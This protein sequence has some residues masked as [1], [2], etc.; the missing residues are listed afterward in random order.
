MT[1]DM[2]DV[3]YTPL[4]CPQPPLID[5]DKL[6]A[7]VNRQPKNPRQWMM[8]KMNYQVQNEQ[9]PWDYITLYHNPRRGSGGP[10]ASADGWLAGINRVFPELIEYL[11]TPF[12]I[13]V[14]EFGNIVLLP[15]R[16]GHSG[17][18]WHRDDD[19]NGMRMYLDHEDSENNHLY[20]R[21]SVERDRWPLPWFY[22][23]TSPKTGFQEEDLLCKVLHPRQCFFL[24]NVRALHSTVT[25]VPGKRRV[26]LLFRDLNPRGDVPCRLNQLSADL[27]LRSAEKFKDHAVLWQPPV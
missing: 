14:E 11:R 19:A 3:L 20:M 4:D 23:A 18:Y 7:W 5:F 17:F 26:T 24:N 10:T 1:N 16:P 9:Y 6:E 22:D 25:N 27:I 21:R 8:S 2:F 12:G 13:P 15:L